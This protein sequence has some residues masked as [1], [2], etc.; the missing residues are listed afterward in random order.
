[1]NRGYVGFRKS[2]GKWF[3]RIQG[4]TPDGKR[5]DRTR[6]GRD[7]AH[8]NELLAQLIAETAGTTGPTTN[9][10]SPA[11]TT[12]GTTT[13]TFKAVADAYSAHKVHPAT[14][15]NDRKVSGL[16]SVRT[17]KLRIKTLVDY[18]GDTDISRITPATV[19]RFKIERLNTPTRD[20]KE[21]SITSVNRELEQLRAIL[22]YARNEGHI[23]ASPF[24][25]ASTPLIS[26]ADEVKRTRILTPDEETRL[27]AA[28]Q[29]PTRAHLYP[30]V[31][32]A[33]DTGARKGELLAVRWSDVSMERMA[34][35]LR[36]MTTKTLK[37]RSV[38]LSDR[39]AVALHQWAV[40]KWGYSGKTFPT[41][42]DRVFPLVKFQNGWD[43]KRRCKPGQK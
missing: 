1:M 8:A 2:D 37:T 25:R 41:T 12:A 31:I 18:F 10:P 32:A 16:R 23:S 9:D 30:L 4:T 36:A 3:A 22:R 43:C 39:L 6:F 29:K 42:D 40:S 17:V 19:D 7:E 13:T 28:C 14:Y 26:K 34:I 21:R 15:R 20:G 35:T 5:I 11:N 24:E 38:P 33:L 27:L